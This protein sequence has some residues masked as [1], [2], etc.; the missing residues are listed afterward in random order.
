MIR[1]NI[2]EKLKKRYDF[3]VLNERV[4][5]LT[6]D[7]LIA[8]VDLF[9]NEPGIVVMEYAENMQEAEKNW[10]EDGELFYLKEFSE[11]EIYNAIIEEIES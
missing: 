6:P 2:E 1:K 11:E 7:R 3:F 10:F 8:R 5:F 9:G 4:C